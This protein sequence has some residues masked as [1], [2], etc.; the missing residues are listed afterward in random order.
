[1]STL[2]RNARA[3]RLARPVSDESPGDPLNWRRLL[4]YLRPY[5]W[6]MALALSLLAG[7][8]AISLAFP[9]VI[10]Q[11]LD[12][13]LQQQNMALLNRLAG[14]L[15]VLFLLQALL[16]FGQSYSLNVIGE[17]IVL[18]LHVAL[19]RHLQSLSLDFFANRR[20]GEII[21]RISSDVTQVRAVLTNNITQLLSNLIALIGSVTIIFL[22]NPRLV[23]F[24][25]V[26]AL[27]VV[28]VAYTFGRR[29]QRLSTRV[30]DTLANATVAVEE[31]LQGVRV[32]KSFARERYEVERY[33]HA[34]QRTLGATLHL[35]L[36]RAPSAG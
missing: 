6:R 36:L 35:A 26:L 33:E 5:Q 16:T 17:R 13:V 20:V 15:L 34:M 4:T 10:V 3:G 2:N 8:S 29:L 7:S 1:M 18:D 12:A 22:L 19:Y 14:A 30:Q 31:G 23:G 24:V 27:S 9:L 21:S 28:A 32:V 25:L 11:L